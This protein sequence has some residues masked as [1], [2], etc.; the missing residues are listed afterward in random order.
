MSNEQDN[1]RYLDK[2]VEL[3]EKVVEHYG[4]LKGHFELQNKDISAMHDDVKSIASGQKKQ[5][6]RFLWLTVI[7]GAI[8]TASVA[9]AKWSNASDIEKL[10]KAVEALQKTVEAMSK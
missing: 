4:K 9:I 3:V 6:S 1:N 7:Y 8:T 10:Q 5:D 2:F